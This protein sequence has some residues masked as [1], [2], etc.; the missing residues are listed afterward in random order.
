MNW[1]DLLIIVVLGIGV[2]HGARK[3]LVRQVL[4]LTSLVGS[5]LAGYLYMEGAG[6]WLASQIGIPM[7]YAMVAGF[8]A[9]FLGV[10]LGFIIVSRLLDKVISDAPLLGGLNKIIG[11]GLGL[12]SAGL[13]LSLILNLG[14]VVGLPSDEIRTSSALYDSAHQFLPQ[15][16]DLA[17]SQFPELTGLGE[18]FS[19]WAQ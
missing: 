13:M 2:L 18:R 12:L 16:W 7:Q 14:S 6:L 9:V 19:A 15:T 17:T 5:L 10:M 3:G 1:I 4:G 8:M 11:A